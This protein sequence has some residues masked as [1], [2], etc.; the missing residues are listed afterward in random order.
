[1]IIPSIDIMDGKAVQLVKGVRKVLEIDDV[2]GLGKK[3]SVY[4]E[5]A[6]IDLDAAIGRK[7]VSGNPIDNANLIKKLCKIA[8]CRVGGGIR[9]VE[10]AIELIRAGASKIIIGTNANPQ[11]LE[12]LPKSKVIAAIDTLGGMVAVEGWTKTTAS[13]PERQIKKLE[14]YCCGFL[15]TNID[16]EGTMKGIDIAKIKILAKLTQRRLTVAGGISS[17]ADLKNIGLLGADSQIGMS[18][19]TGKID[20][21]EAFAA[22][23]EFKPHV[24]Y[25]R[26]RALIPTIV[27]DESGQ[28]LMLAY[29][30]EQSVIMSLQQKRGIYYSRSR[31]EI[32]RKGDTSGNIQELL[33]VSYDCDS[34]ALLYKV[35][36]KN[37]ACHEGSYSCFGEKEFDLSRLYDIVKERIRQNNASSYTAQIAQNES[38]ILK[39]IAEESQEVI[40]YKNRSNLVWEIADLSYFITVLMAAKNISISEVMA[41]LA[42]RNTVKNG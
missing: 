6:V 25:G 29:S 7:D 21:D 4:G 5:I 41:E 38:S 17:I 30:T 32:W 8:R 16:V 22:M 15:Y 20:L 26:K 12:K 28:I 1:M 33:K 35:R 39:K 27:Q 31:D 9:T 14:D 34:D 37:S 40:S 13:K 42:S 36:Q 2:I 19:Y 11:F 24:I 18:L 23:L 3:Y 10:K